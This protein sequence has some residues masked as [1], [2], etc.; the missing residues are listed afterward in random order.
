VSAWASA[1]EGLLEPI[2]RNA[3]DR[4]VCWV[5]MNGPELPA[6]ISS[7]P[8]TFNDLG[9]RLGRGRTAERPVV[10]VQ[11]LGFVG[12]AM[13]IAVAGA[14][15]SDS[16]PWFNVVGVD[17][18]TAAGRERAEQ[19]N[20]GELPLTA[21]DPDL[22]EALKLANHEG[23]LIATTEPGS[24][25]LADVTVVDINLDVD[26]E[27]RTIDFE[28]FRKAIKA[29]GDWMRPGS[30]VLV[31]TTVPPGTCRHLVMPTLRSGLQ[32]RGLPGDAILVAHSYER[33]MPGREYLRSIVELPRVY[34]A[35]EELAALA[36]RS[37]LEKVIH[38]ERSR[39]TRLKSTIA[40]ETSK[41]V[42]N[43]YRAVNIAFIDEWSRFAEAVGVDLYEVVDAIRTRPTHANIRRPG[44]G[45][46][47]YCLTKDPLMGEVAARQLFDLK[48][49]EF[50][51]SRLAVKVNEEM[52]LRSVERLAYALG[53]SLA[54]REILVLGVSYRADIGDTRWSPSET[55][56]RG[57]WERSGTVR[58][59]DPLVRFWPELKM[60]IERAL[61]TASG[62]D[63]VV[64]AVDH[65]EY[66][67]LDLR[68]WL[69]PCRPVLF[70]ASRVLSPGQRKEALSLGC[71]IWA[72]G[73]GV[74][75]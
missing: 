69:G 36:C 57:I 70:D 53:G 60:G 39:L 24:Y 7:A 45:V 16:T 34:A 59:H 47:G 61:P 18:P 71:R 28:P 4:G 12:C 11:G 66:K 51:F 58:A 22:R 74:V 6:G 63:A 37:F 73:D 64:F 43:S 21:L 67:Q 27:R 62:A 56:V 42:E 33:I 68:S 19:V 25:A 52:P 44:L 75:Y 29:L 23:N 38:P 2:I 9:K 30:L 49:S 3:R 54:G 31:E 10:C 8:Q 72:P 50:P 65:E 17:Q 41:I 5:G 32:A 1:P 26:R 46:G 35:D 14:R 15:R 20:R 48:V 40:S 13:A 55:L